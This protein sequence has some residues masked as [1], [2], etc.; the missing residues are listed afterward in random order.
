MG[1]AGLSQTARHL[2]RSAPRW[3]WTV[4]AAV[5]A[6]LGSFLGGQGGSPQ[7][8]ISSPPQQSRYTPP[9]PSSPI[10]VVAPVDQRVA[11][12]LSEFYQSYADADGIKTREGARCERLAQALAP[13]GAAERDAAT[14]AQRA[15]IAEADACRS[16][17]EASDRRL[18]AAAEA[19][20]RFRTAPS[21]ALAAAA[22]E[23]A[24]RLN[25]FDRSRDFTGGA[26]SPQAL[27]QLRQALADHRSLLE[28]ART[29][30]SLYRPNDPAT[31]DLAVQLAGIGTKVAA[32]PFPA[33]DPSLSDSDRQAL[34]TAQSA[35]KALTESDRR[36][37]VLRQALSRKESDQLGLALALAALTPF[38]RARAAATGAA[39]T[40]LAQDAARAA[41]PE[42]AR[43]LAASYR[44]AP[45][46]GDAESLVQLAEMAATLG[47]TIDKDTVAATGRA[48]TDLSGSETRLAALR[49][50]AGTWTVTRTSGERN[51]AVEARVA[52]VLAAIVPPGTAEANAYDAEGMG[53]EERRALGELL[54]ASVQ[55][56]SR[57]PPGQRRSVTVFV[58]ATALNDRIIAALPRLVEQEIERAG[59]SLV[60]SPRQ[61][62]ITVHLSDPAIR[63]AGVDVSTGQRR[64]QVSVSGT[65]LWGYTGRRHEFGTIT[66]VGGARDSSRALTE[67]MGETAKAVG[68]A[69]YEN[70]E[71]R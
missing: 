41:V 53:E 60:S 43:S 22:T 59:F 34:V 25:D 19:H 61:A 52:Q 6:T 1:I 42:A 4:V 30:R 54:A 57:L 46:R 5:V 31:L 24:Q 63:D 3:R 27:D 67:A 26:F 62:A 10:N 2:W 45:R 32:L 55:I 69:I 71:G 18:A 50:A 70:L 14:H 40:G 44:K 48:R 49:E 28:D 16:Q 21:V 13:L 37:E 7:S 17:V 64:R 68:K 56:Q 38:D 33:S 23:H 29:R 20:G 47:A 12:R 51:P 8:G 9:A 39:D 36:I 35:A 58:D 11:Q 65:L 66:G 15:A